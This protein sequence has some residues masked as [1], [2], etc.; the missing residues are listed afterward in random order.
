LLRQGV[1]DLDDVLLAT[2]DTQ[3]RLFVSR[4]GQGDDGSGGKKAGG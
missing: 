3:G 2:L 1:Q 4:K